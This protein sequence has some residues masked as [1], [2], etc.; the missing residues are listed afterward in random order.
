MPLRVKDYNALAK[1]FREVTDHLSEA[2]DKPAY[3]TL[4]IAASNVADYCHD[5]NSHFDK[6]RFMDEAG[7]AE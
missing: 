1:C 7:F 5:G 3:L 6:N 4:K 2:T